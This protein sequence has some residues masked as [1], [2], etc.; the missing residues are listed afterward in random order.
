MPPKIS[1]EHI[2]EVIRDEIA[3]KYPEHA[4]A[5]GNVMELLIMKARNRINRVSSRI[6]VANPDN[7]I[8]FSLEDIVKQR[9]KELAYE[10]YCEFIKEQEQEPI[11]FEEFRKASTGVASTYNFFLKL[12]RM[13][14]K[15]GD[16]V[17]DSEGKIY[18]VV[19]ISNKC[20]PILIGENGKKKG[21]QNL[22]GFEKFSD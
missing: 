18:T 17:K 20:R 22:I 5:L 15:T 7:L 11:E 21:N 12:M 19:K 1:D 14:I 13:G 9:E 6:P 4:E 16:Q 2:E 3:E 8:S 10:E